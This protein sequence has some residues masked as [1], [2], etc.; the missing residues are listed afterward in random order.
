MR[1][2]FVFYRTDSV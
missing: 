1:R 2:Y